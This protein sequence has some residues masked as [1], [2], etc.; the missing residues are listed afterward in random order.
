ML[1]TTNTRMR[2]LVKAG[3]T[4]DQSSQRSH[5]RISMRVSLAFITVERYIRI[6]F[7]DAS[8]AVSDVDLMPCASGSR[9]RS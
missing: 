3:R 1:A 4:E 2:E 6:L 7:R 9:S 5:L 8:R